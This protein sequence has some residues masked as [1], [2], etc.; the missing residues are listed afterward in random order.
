VIPY[1][2]WVPVA[3]RLVAN[4]YIRLCYLHTHIRTHRTQ[5]PSLEY[6]S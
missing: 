4:C 2:T 1:S 6:L 5:S 3:V